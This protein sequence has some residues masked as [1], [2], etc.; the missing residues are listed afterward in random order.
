VASSPSTW[1]KS[2]SELS[3]AP[4]RH[5]TTNAADGDNSEQRHMFALKQIKGDWLSSSQVGFPAFLLR[6]LDFTSRVRHPNIIRTEEIVFQRDLVD[7]DDRRNE[8]K[9]E[10]DLDTAAP[11]VSPTYGVSVYGVMRCAWKDVKEYLRDPGHGQH[12]AQPGFRPPYL[13]LSRRNG[14][15]DAVRSFVGRVKNICKQMFEGLAC[16]HEHRI[17]HRDLKLTN[18]LLHQDGRLQICDFGLARHWVRREHLTPTVVTLMYRAPELHFGVVDYDTSLDMWSAGCIMAE[19]FLKMPLFRA[20]TETEHLGRVCDVLGFPSDDTFSG[21][22][23][24]DAVVNILSGLLADPATRVVGSES[25]SA[26]PPPPPPSTTSRLRDFLR[27]GGELQFPLHRCYRG[28][29]VLASLPACMDLIEQLLQWNPK[30]RPSA[31]EVLAHPFFTTELPLPCDNSELTQPMPLQVS[32]P[33]AI[34][35]SSTSSHLRCSGN[36]AAIGAPTPGGQTVAVPQASA[37]VE[38]IAAGEDAK[39]THAAA[40]MEGRDAAAAQQA[41]EATAGE[42]EQLQLTVAE[43]ATAPSEEVEENDDDLLMLW[44][45]AEDERAAAG[46]QNLHAIAM[47]DTDDDDGVAAS[48]RRPL[49]SMSRAQDESSRDVER[50]STIDRDESREPTPIPLETTTA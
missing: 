18:M 33:A 24:S 49:M 2:V 50:Q 17:Q 5:H 40:S 16:L 25:A 9:G 32:P 23:K 38:C 42:S 3:S 36:H 31:R 6:E 28:A 13:H 10:A 22:Y 12:P 35:A 15:P 43:V 19:L 45:A 26:T 20:M 44:T 34:D 14:H 11:V 41:S 48:A 39:P 7:L 27:H 47:K 8:K 1:D 46:D 29:E 30:N 4:S 37:E 21:I